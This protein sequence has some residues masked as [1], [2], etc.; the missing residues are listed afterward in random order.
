MKVVNTKEGEK[1]LTCGCPWQGQVRCG[2]CDCCK[3]ECC[4]CPDLA[5]RLA[6]VMAFNIAQIEAQE[7]QPP[8]ALVEGFNELLHAFNPNRAITNYL[9]LPAKDAPKQ[10]EAPKVNTNEGSDPW[11]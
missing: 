7:E 1:R 9:P 2:L 10:L 4:Q 11:I 8:K 3:D 5:L 6:G